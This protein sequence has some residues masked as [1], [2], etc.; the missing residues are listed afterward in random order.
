MASVSSFAYAS[1]GIERDIEVFNKRHFSGSDGKVAGVSVHTATIRISPKMNG[2][3]EYRFEVYD[4]MTAFNALMDMSRQYDFEVQTQTFDLGVY[5]DAIGEYSSG[6]NNR[7]WMYY[8]NNE[9]ALESADN[10]VVQSD[11]LI[12]FKFEESIY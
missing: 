12:E 2:V 11:D 3:G 5:V 1:I 8:M 6:Q 10:T 9:F 4:D 7:Y